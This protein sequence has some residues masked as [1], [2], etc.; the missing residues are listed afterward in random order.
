MSHSSIP[1]D[2]GRVEQELRHL[3]RDEA[4]KSDSGPVLCSRTLNLI[5]YCRSLADVQRATELLDPIVSLHPCRAIVVSPAAPQAEE[6]IHT[7]VSASC[8]TSHGGNRYIGRELVSLSAK[9]AAH[10]RLASMVRA[11]LLPDLPVFLWWRDANSLGSELFQHLSELAQRIIVDSA[12][13]EDLQADWPRVHALVQRPNVAVSDLAWSRLTSWRQLIAQLFDGAARASY[14]RKLRRIVVE[15]G[16]G[17]DA[18]SVP[19][20]ALLLGAWLARQLGFRNPRPAAPDLAAPDDVAEEKVSGAWELSSGDLRLRVE[21]RHGKRAGAGVTAVF[22]TCGDNGQAVFVVSRTQ[23]G[24]GLATR[25][26]LP[27]QAAMRRLVRI[28]DESASRLVSSELEILGR[29]VLYEQVLR[30]AGEL[31]PALSPA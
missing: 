14:L 13:L 8:L 2:A 30:M 3:W 16:N 10:R 1:A 18:S 24:K 15:F 20:D 7:E 22:L 4:E 12:G 17:G 9:P 25:A 29:D 23:D 31:V 11:L 26:E 28:G 5:V 21:V 6:E 27:G 19:A